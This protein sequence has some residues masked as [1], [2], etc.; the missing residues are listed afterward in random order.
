[1]F[2][3]HVIKTKDQYDRY[4]EE[5]FVYPDELYEATK[6][7][8]KDSFSLLITGAPGSGKSTLLQLL[9]NRTSDKVTKAIVYGRLLIGD[10]HSLLE[11]NSD[12][13]YLD[14]LEDAQSPEDVLG[15]IKTKGFKKIIC[16][17]R[18][19]YS[20]KFFTDII[21][22]NGL[23]EEKI[24]ILLDKM[25]ID[26]RIIHSANTNELIK[27]FFTPRDILR[28]I[29]SGVDISESFKFLQNSK[30]FLYR[31]GGGVGFSSNNI[32][33]DELVVPPK[34]IITQINAFEESL[35]KKAKHSPN[36]IHDF[37]PREFEKFI[38]QFFDAQGMEVKLT[39]PT[40]DGGKDLIVVQ[41]S[42]LG[43]FS[44]YVECKKYDA[45][46]P[47]SV[48]LIRELYGTVM[49]DSVTAGLLITTSYFTKDAQEYTEQIKNRMS[50]MDY[51]DLVK[52]LNNLYI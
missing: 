4:F 15:F 32:V 24:N 17:S 52:S 44:I 41:K 50:L 36:I 42:I 31:F 48:S 35:L 34:R 19:I 22:L 30:N 18:E 28:L 20:E 21:T 33:R 26:N 14:G 29:A 1:M 7:I 46:R 45:R 40:R 38:Y 5:R 25:R 47:I 11:A 16:T 37:T 13:L 8:E 43:E 51:S 3:E 49:A 23:S 39:K 12:Y 6:V 9:N 27:A 10:D 2:D